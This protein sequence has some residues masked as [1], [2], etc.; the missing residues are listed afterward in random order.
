MGFDKA[1]NID[2]R[3]SRI[4]VL[5][6]LSWSYIERNSIQFDPIESIFVESPFLETHFFRVLT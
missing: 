5:N 3:F 2:I 1:G 4:V 6:Y